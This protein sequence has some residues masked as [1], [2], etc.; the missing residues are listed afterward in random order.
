MTLKLWRALNN[1]PATHPIFVR[2]VLL[3]RVVKRRSIN[4]A[5]IIIGFIMSM[6]EFMPTVL[7]FLM[8]V[9]LGGCGLIYGLDCAVRVSQ[10]ITFERRNNTYPLLVLCPPGAL[11][12]CWAM[13]TSLLYQQQQFGRLH[14]IV[15]TSTRIAF[16]TI[17][18]ILMLFIAISI[19]IIVSSSRL[20][21]P[22]ITPLI[23]AEAVVVLIYS[24]YVQSTVIGCLIGVIISTFATGTMD[25]ILYAPAVFLLIKIGG[26]AASILVGF[27]LLERVYQQI[28]I[29]GGL[30]DILLTLARV[31]IIVVVQD[32]IIRLLWRV[33]IKQTDTVPQEAELALYPPRLR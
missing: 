4:S 25:S 24:E 33:A 15:R 11:A 26:Y 2:T 30:T 31:V 23:N 28:A 12:V 19:S 27:N 13:C 3:P 22:I 16:A 7:I 20:A 18:V 8:P 17:A 6:S 5:S 10:L 14:E 9:L 21:L 1:P 32:L 29:Q